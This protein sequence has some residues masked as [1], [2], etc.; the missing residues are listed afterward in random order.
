MDALVGPDGKPP[1]FD[2]AVWVSQDRR[3]WWNGTAWE[4]VK[5][6]GFHP[7]IA[8]FVIVV[9]ILAGAWFVLQHLPKAAPEPYGVTN[10]K[11]DS[12]TQF[13]FDYRSATACKDTTFLYRFYDQAGNK[14]DERPGE[15]HTAVDANKTYHVTVNS[16][17]SVINAKAVRFEAL[18]TCH[19]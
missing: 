18:P 1:N 15:Q 14:V 3:Y 11:I 2:G 13:E 5:G 19:A 8:V 17:G 6:R 7:P 10:A 12:N 16:F 4:R 9:V